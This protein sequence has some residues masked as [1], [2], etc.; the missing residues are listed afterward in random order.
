ML[1]WDLVCSVQ[2]SHAPKAG[3]VWNTVLLWIAWYWTY[4]SL[5][6]N[7]LCVLSLNFR[8]NIKY[9][10]LFE[11]E[12][13]ESVQRYKNQCDEVIEEVEQ[14]L[15]F[16]TVLKTDYVRV[17]TKTNA[18]HEA[19]ENLLEEQVTSLT[20]IIISVP[21]SVKVRL[22]IPYCFHVQGLILGLKERWLWWNV[23]T[24]IHQ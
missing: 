7:T 17:A 6:A 11:R 9:N 3:T 5:G 16:L 12:F 10:V 2:D 23:M 18:L 20:F 4:L 13:L 15:E 14:C 24:K 8:L 19:C 1:R 22:S 21:W